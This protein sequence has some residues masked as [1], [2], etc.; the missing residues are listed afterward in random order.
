M[1]V[2]RDELK[3]KFGDDLANNDALLEECA[4]LCSHHGLDADNFLW[5]WEA[6]KWEIG[7]DVRG[8]PPHFDADKLAAIRAALHRQLADEERQR[9]KVRAAPVA[10][11]AG[12]AAIRGMGGA[13]AM[14]GMPGVRSGMAAAGAARALPPFAQRGRAAPVKAE[15]MDVDMSAPV[16]ST[17]ASASIS[18]ATRAAHLHFVGPDMSEDARKARAYRYMYATLTE[19]AAAL[20]DRID[21]F[22]DLVKAYYGIKVEGGK[23]PLGDPAEMTETTT[24]VV[25]CITSDTD[26]GARVKLTDSTLRIETSRYLGRKGS[27]PLKFATGFRIVA[28][29]RTAVD[30]PGINQSAGSGSSHG[31]LPGGGV[32]TLFPGAI[33]ALRGRNGA[34]TAF[35]AEEAWCS[36]RYPLHDLCLW[37]NQQ[38]HS[39]ANP[40]LSVTS[41]AASSSPFTLTVLA[42]PYTADSDLTFAPWQ[43]ALTALKEDAPDVVVLLGPFIDSSHPLI[44]A[45]DADESMG[46]MFTRRFLMPLRRWL[47]GVGEGTSTGEQAGK[48]GAGSG[49]KGRLAVMIPSVR[50]ALSNHLAFPQ[51][52]LTGFEGFDERIRFLPNPARFCV[53]GVSFAATS[54]ETVFHLQLDRLLKRASSA[55]D[56]GDP[57]ANCTSFYPL[58]P[59]PQPADLHLDVAHAR[60][61][62]MGDMS[63][64]EGSAGA[65]TSKQPAVGIE[66]GGC[67]DGGGAVESRGW[68]QCAPDIL[69]VPTR[70][71]E[72]A[73]PVTNI[74]S[75]TSTYATLAV[76]PSYVTKGRH[77]V[78]QIDPSGRSLDGVETAG[79]VKVSGEVRG[80]RTG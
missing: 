28:P 16:A 62:V 53:N 13:R 45:G 19:R 64:A 39:A 51:A 66:E 27:T 71:K 54:V 29:W 38:C 50:D 58:F 17:S 24:T 8:K 22:A 37:R 65:T 57:V 31:L 18:S 74:L 40:P 23:E 61:L 69:I 6:M 80:H 11:G 41:T 4:Q 46:R 20:D 26:D 42:G 59:G 7:K 36:P 55:G 2:L 15:P 75:S 33:V 35:V 44:K 21:D 43:G 49:P 67:M 70:L 47:N 30:M 14:G 12:V 10:A 1:D 79:G 76:N 52:E 56:A 72:M 3:D 60:G 63:P 9:T 25:G 48:P 73:K 5:K 78:L 68:E 34:G 77:A 32:L